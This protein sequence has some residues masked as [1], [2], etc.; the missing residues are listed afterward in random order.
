MP[1]SS[2]L[3][4]QSRIYTLRL[5]LRLLSL[6]SSSNM[7]KESTETARFRQRSSRAVAILFADNWPITSD[8]FFNY[9]QLATWANKWTICGPIKIDWFIDWWNFV[10]L[11][12]AC[13]GGNTGNKALQLAKQQCCPSSCKKMLP[14]LLRLYCSVAIHSGESPQPSGKRRESY[15]TL[16]YPNTPN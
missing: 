10:A 7:L 11:Q 14:V 3:E 13:R 6:C 5:R 8:G 16:L 4:I 2:L 15:K 9:T 1:L 12:V